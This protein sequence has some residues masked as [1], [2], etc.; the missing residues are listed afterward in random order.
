ML[1]PGRPWPLRGVPEPSARVPDAFFV[2]AR[3][4]LHPRVQYPLHDAFQK[5]ITKLNEIYL[6]NPA[7]HSGEYNMDNFRWI[8]SDNCEQCVYIFERSC[9][10]STVLCVFNFSG[11]KQEVSFTLGKTA[12]LK[13]ILNSR[14]EEY[15]GDVPRGTK[16]VAPK[17]DIFTLTVTPLTGSLF[18]VI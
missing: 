10:G 17:K 2:Y 11:M 18:E 9:G 6:K 16:A 12:K 7:L 14:W 3:G 4:T 8:M 15:G 1:P 13:E 5:Y